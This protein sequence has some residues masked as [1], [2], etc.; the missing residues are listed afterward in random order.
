MSLGLFVFQPITRK[1]IS[2]MICFGPLAESVSETLQQGIC[3]IQASVDDVSVL[4]KDTA[5]S[6]FILSAFQFL[7]WI[8]DTEA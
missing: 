1:V 2:L 3:T 5:D 7:K 4:V 8:T 6:G